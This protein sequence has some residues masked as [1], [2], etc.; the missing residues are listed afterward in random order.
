MSCSLQRTACCYFLS[1]TLK[2]I[3]VGDIFTAAE[4]ISSPV[5]ITHI[6]FMLLN[7]GTATGPFFFYTFCT[8]LTIICLK[9]QWQ[10]L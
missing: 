1:Y 9:K 10:V 4:G 6:I 5:S 3:F 7:Y 8:V 2:G